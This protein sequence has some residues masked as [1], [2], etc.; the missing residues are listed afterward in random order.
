MNF[1]VDKNCSDIC[2]GFQG[3]SAKA[4][5]LHYYKLRSDDISALTPSNLIS[6]YLV[7][8]KGHGMVLNTWENPLLILYQKLTRYFLCYF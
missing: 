4:L 3:N 8:R 1:F 5:Q 2:N 7:M 6:K